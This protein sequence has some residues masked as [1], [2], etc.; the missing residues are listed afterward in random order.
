[1]NEIIL[2]DILRNLTGGW[3]LDLR[4]L[5]KVLERHH[6]EFDDVMDSIDSC[7]WDEIKLEFNAIIYETLN[8]IAL[9]FIDENK[10]LFK[11]HKDDFTIYCNYMDSHIFFED[12]EVQGKFEGYF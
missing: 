7:Y 1:M 12:E 3:Y 11:S 8:M 2:T 5:V 10:N 6:L 9:R 4:Y